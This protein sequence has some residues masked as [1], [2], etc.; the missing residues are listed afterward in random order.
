[1]SE[2]VGGAVEATAARLER[3]VA[4]LIVSPAFVVVRE[5]LIGLVDLFE[6]GL[7]GRIPRV[8]IGMVLQRLALVRLANFVGRRG[9]FDTQ[10]LVVIAFFRHGRAFD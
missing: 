4:E 1:V 5:D 9:P 3:R 6:L 10:D 8:P 7:G 2:D